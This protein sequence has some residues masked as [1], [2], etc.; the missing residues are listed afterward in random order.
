MIFKYQSNRIYHA[1]QQGKVLA[2][3]L[4]PYEEG[5]IANITHTV[6]DDSLKGQG[7]AGKLVQMAVEEIE[8]SHKTPKFTCPYA[9]KWAEKNYKKC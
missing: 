5:N 9:A 2:E 1:N 7:I 4:F 6:V 8:R 3:I